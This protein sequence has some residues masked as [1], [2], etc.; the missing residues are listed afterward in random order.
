M[1]FEERITE[2]LVSNGM[3]V[4]YAAKVIKLAKA[5]KVNDAMKGRWQ[6]QVDSCPPVILNMLWLGVR[7]T[8]L[9]WID[10]NIPNAWF[11]PLFVEAEVT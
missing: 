1:T 5:D 4:D 8:A 3:A 11:R 10:E 6:D 2:L 7:R 9:S